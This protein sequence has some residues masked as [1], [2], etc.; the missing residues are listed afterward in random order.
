MFNLKKNKFSNQLNN[1]LFRKL[2]KISHNLFLMSKFNL[3]INSLKWMNFNYIY[4]IQM[5][6]FNESITHETSV[7]N[8]NLFLEI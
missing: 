3:F 4:F 2:F 8:L 7:N 6:K 1:V 5:E